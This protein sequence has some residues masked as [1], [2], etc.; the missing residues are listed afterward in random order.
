MVWT[1]E[2]AAK[3]LEDDGLSVEILDLRTLVPWDRKAVLE[4][5]AKTSKVLVLHEDT[6]T[7]GF[8][9]EI[10]ATIAE[11]AFEDLDAP[12]KRLTAPDTP[13][14]FSPPLE[15]AFIPQVD[16]VASALREL[17]EY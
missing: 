8:G 10:A 1:A 12:V 2:E 13:V 9:G 4:S 15:K 7:G 17:A 14:P 11:E 3:Q 6:H 5:V 16:D